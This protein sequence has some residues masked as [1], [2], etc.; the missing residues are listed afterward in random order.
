MGG[1][2]RSLGVTACVA[3][4]GG[5]K[6]CADAYKKNSQLAPPCVHRFC[7]FTIHSTRV[8]NA[9]KHGEHDMEIPPG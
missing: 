2:K 9:P 3:I 1:R 5:Y 7:S 8:T 4:G 6:W